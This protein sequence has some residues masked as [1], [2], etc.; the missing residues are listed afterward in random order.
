MLK[1]QFQIEVLEVTQKEWQ[2]IIDI[3]AEIIR[4]PARLIMRLEGPD[5][6]VFV[7][8]NSEHSCSK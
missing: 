1:N 8:S 6:E 7:S 3:M 2:E 5:I 4:I